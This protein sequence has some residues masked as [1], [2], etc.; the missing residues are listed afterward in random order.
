MSSFFKWNNRHCLVSFSRLIISK[1]YVLSPTNTK[2]VM[3]NSVYIP[4][5]LRML[6]N[7]KPVRF[8]DM[9]TSTGATKVS[10]G[11]SLPLP[12]IIPGSVW[13]SWVKTQVWLKCAGRGLQW[14]E[15]EDVVRSFTYWTRCEVFP[16]IPSHVLF[17][18]S[19][20]SLAAKVNWSSS[21][22]G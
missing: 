16:P 5:R 6:A 4:H 7:K 17:T 11:A 10:Q 19:S 13:R 12:K 21:S 9:Y 14:N 18:A 15:V 1:D 20:C 3:N 2:A 22:S 8:L